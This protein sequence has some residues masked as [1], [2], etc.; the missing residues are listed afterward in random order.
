MAAKDTA[1]LIALLD[2]I[3]RRNLLVA[4]KGSFEQFAHNF[5]KIRA[6]NGQLS[7]FTLNQPQR[8]LHERLEEQKAKTG[9]VRALVLKGRQQGASTYISGRFYWKVKHTQGFQ[10]F[11]L[12]HEQAATDNL[13]GMVERYYKNDPSPL[14]TSAA[15]AKELLFPQRDSGYSVGTAGTKSVGRSKTIQLLHGSEAAFW[16]NAASHFASVVQAVPD[17]PDTEIILES[18]ANGVDGEFFDRW[19]QA[20]AGIGDY[21]AIFIPWYWSNEYARPVPDGFILDDEEVDYQRLYGLSL[22]QMVWRRAKIAE[23]KDPLLFKQE[24]P[25][26]AAEAFQTTG[27]DSFIPAHIVLEARKTEVEG[28]GPLV[29]GVDPS[30]F[31]DDTFAIAW[32]RGRKVEKIERRNKLDAMAGASWVKQIIDDEADNGEPVER[33]FVD[34]G[35]VGGPVVDILKSWGAPYSRIVIPV[36][37]GGGPR[38]PVRIGSD[39]RA[40]PG[41]LN[42]RAEMWSLSR[43]WLKTEGGVSIPDDDAL[44]RDAAAPGYRYNLQQKLVLESKEDI[45]KRGGRSPDGWD[46][47]ALTFAEPVKDSSI[48]RPERYVSR[49]SNRRRNSAWAV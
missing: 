10:C 9:K 40:L 18:T 6:K 14:A 15:N 16:P 34:A 39:G 24:F 48:E 30:R 5:L 11:I 41:P 43:D 21:Q 28:L 12:T 29:L 37:F 23:L 36:D 47:V 32:R 19:Q 46:A 4:A 20:E 1:N 26:N 2:E 17:L 42:R 13:F 33:C 25:A 45:R 7:T 38:Q 35:G 49:A 3:Q 8:Y 27:H 31:G 44:Q 22:E